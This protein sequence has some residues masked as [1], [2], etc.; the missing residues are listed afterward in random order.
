V[1]DI[2]IYNN[3][4]RYIK[5]FKD[6]VSVLPSYFFRS[7]FSKPFWLRKITSDSHILG[8]VNIECPDDKYPKLDICISEFI[9]DS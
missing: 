2:L 4:F 8:R 9:L 3:L 5:H 6:V 1:F 7:V